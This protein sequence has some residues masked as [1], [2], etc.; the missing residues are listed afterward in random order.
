MLI[1]A[2]KFYITILCIEEKRA[3]VRRMGDGDGDGDDGDG[4]GDAG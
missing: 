3:S 2:P 4:D 1:Q